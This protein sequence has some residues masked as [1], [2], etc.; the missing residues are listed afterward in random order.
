MA[1]CFVAVKFGEGIGE[2]LGQLQQKARSLG[3]DATF[4]KEF[5]ATLAFLG[6]ID[7]RKIEEAKRKLDS[8]QSRPAEIKATG[9]G[10]FPS[11][12]FVKVFWAGVS[13]LEVLQRQVAAALE[14]EGR[15][16][17]HVTLSR[18]KTQRNLQSLK[19][20]AK[21]YERKEFGT[22]TVNEVILFKSN[23]SP[24]GPNYEELFVKKL[25]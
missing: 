23:L 3:L 14:H 17:C 15:F 8:L 22:A 11:E 19:Q 16:E 5:H 1:R 10:F 25:S 21:D 7:E 2:K 20:L 6:E 12:K 9:V 4:P 18:V 24:S 13:G